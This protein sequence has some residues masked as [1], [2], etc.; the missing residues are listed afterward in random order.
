MA[1]IC[2]DY[3]SSSHNFSM[4]SPW[5]LIAIE[6]FTGFPP[7]LWPQVSHAHRG[8]YAA[9][10][11]QPHCTLCPP[12]RTTNFEAAGRLYWAVLTNILGKSPGECHWGSRFQDPLFFLGW[13]NEYQGVVSLWFTRRKHHL[14]SA[15]ADPAGRHGRRTLPLRRKSLRGKVRAVRKWHTS[16]GLVEFMP[17]PP[18]YPWSTWHVKIKITQNDACK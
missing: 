11:G 14:P 7:C 4:M 17:R 6:V 16:L 5:F 9:E 12:G 3:K 8:E 1:W 2:L 10:N 15:S 18:I 13:N